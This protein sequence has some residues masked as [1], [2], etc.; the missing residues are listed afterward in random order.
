M[1]KFPLLNLFLSLPITYNYIYRLHFS[2][3]SFT[4]ILIPNRT[5][6][7]LLQYNTTCSVFLIYL[8][9]PPS[10]FHPLFFL[11]SL[12]PACLPLISS[13]LSLLI[14]LS[15]S[16]L[17]NYLALFWSFLFLDIS[18][19]H[20]ISSFTNFLLKSS[21]TLHWEVSSTCR[22]DNILLFISF[23]N[24]FYIL[25]SHCISSLHLTPSELVLL[26]NLY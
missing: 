1:L 19:S 24:F 23:A 11:S 6:T 7:L 4:N 14:P 20:C 17:Y 12:A 9:F 10:P 2:F 26:W 8:L 22:C 3:T 5:P 18:N 21:I 13:L 16:I 25:N 15:S